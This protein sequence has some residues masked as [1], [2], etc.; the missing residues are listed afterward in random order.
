[1]A[2]LSSAAAVGDLIPAVEEQRQH[3]HCQ[4]PQKGGTPESEPEAKPAALPT[5]VIQPC[6]KG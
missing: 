1:M 2:A 6:S 3:R 4:L 5:Y